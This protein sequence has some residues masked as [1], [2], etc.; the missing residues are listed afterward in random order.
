MRLETW[1]KEGVSKDIYRKYGSVT[2]L[3]IATVMASGDV[4]Q[5]QITSGFSP[6]D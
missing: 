1:R 2:D 4:A 5:G 6:W 3:R